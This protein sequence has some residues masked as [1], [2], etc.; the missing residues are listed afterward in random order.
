MKNKTV[1]F[2]H[3]CA[4]FSLFI[5]GNGVF[6]SP[7]KTADEY[8]F[9]GYLT[10][11]VCAFLLYLGV[12]P[13]ANKL[14]KEDIVKNKGKLARSCLCVIYLAVALFA[15]WNGAST[16]KAFTDF[17]GEVI[18]PETSK[19]L[20]TLIFG[21]VCLFFASR[22]QEDVLKFCL[23]AFWFVLALIIFFFLAT[24]KDFNL[25]NIFVFRL[26]EL[27]NLY[28][29]TKP[30][31]LNPVLPCLLLPV[32]NTLVFKKSRKNA[33]FTGLS[34]G[35]C[36]LGICVLGSVLL[37]GPQFAGKLSYPYASAVSTVTVGR[38]FT[39]MD[40][41]SYFIYFAC[42]ITKITACIFIMYSCLKRINYCSA[43]KQESIP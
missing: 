30:Y 11:V 17:V 21:L 25:R 3:T 22:R 5:L 9:L 39:R 10:A 29:Q 38:L 41:F 8:T 18:L 40:G 1:F 43:T 36:L 14:F 4:L 32:Y 28:L 24:L 26:P 20:I 6:T 12:I 35:A 19:P 27:K 16:F 2:T 13:L 15:L 37:F 7:V 33:A 31:I 34:I 42:A 23:I